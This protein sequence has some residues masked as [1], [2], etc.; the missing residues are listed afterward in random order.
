[1]EE[2]KATFAEGMA[3][4]AAVFAFLEKEITRDRK[5]IECE[6]CG[7]WPCVCGDPEFEAWSSAELDRAAEVD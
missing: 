1:M 3:R 4:L 5:E 2:T 6:R 7:Y